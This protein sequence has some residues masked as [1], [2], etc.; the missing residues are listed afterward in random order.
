MFVLLLVADLGVERMEL[1]V[2]RSIA[3]GIKEHILTPAGA[4]AAKG[5]EDACSEGFEEGG[6]SRYY[7]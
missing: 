2:I 3:P 6:Y 1:S 4:E 5:Q 7:Y